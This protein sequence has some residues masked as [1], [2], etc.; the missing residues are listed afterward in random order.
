MRAYRLQSD[1]KREKR[2]ES[3]NGEV[4]ILYIQ[5]ASI[6]VSYCVYLG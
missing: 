6:I 2:K 5:V 1:K 3:S 4:Q